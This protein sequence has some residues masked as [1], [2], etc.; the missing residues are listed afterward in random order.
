[1]Q[2][3]NAPSKLTLPFANGG[4]RNAI[5][6]ESQ[7]GI[8]AGAASLTDGFPPLTR[9]PLAAGGVPPSGLDM[10][11]ILY[12]LSAILR[13]ANAGGGYV[14]DGTFAADPNVSGYPKGARVL[15]SD[16]AGYWLN[17]ID[18]NTVD[19]ESVT[20]NAAQVAGWVP[21]L[22][23]GI[24]AVTMTS[25]NVT[26]TPMQYGKPIV[27][28]SGTLTANLNLIF[29]NLV[30][31]W[32]IINNCTGSFSITAKTSAGSGL[33]IP[34]GGN[35]LIYGD[36]TNIASLVASKGVQRFTTNGSFTVPAG[37]TTIYVSG[38]AGGGGGGGGGGTS[39][40]SSYVGGGGGGGGGSGQSIIQQAYSVTPGQVIPITVGGAGTGG[41]GSSSSNTGGSNGGFGGNT[42]IGTLITLGGGGGGILGGRSI[43]N[44]LGGGGAGSPGGS[45]YPNGSSGTD[46]NYTGNG[47]AGASSPFGGG[48]VAGRASTSPGLS[49]YT[50]GGFGSGGGGGGGSYGA[51]GNAGGAGG[52]GAP[53][54]VIIEW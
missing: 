45:G 11:G 53:G 33:T 24:A 36:G 18:G 21:D 50:S 5:P 52:A 1:M 31:E 12:E 4:G 22:T 39:G 43:A 17:T 16:G 37:V 48:G 23:N 14:Y 7:I 13:W 9:T 28:L 2:L 35:A 44:T 15:R 26:L 8:V 27:V 10:N 51:A 41:T 54:I 19:P 6:V 3:T 38:C 20:V 42:I 32:A 25:T 40:Q 30:G 29:P 46:G 34:A 49:G 47:G